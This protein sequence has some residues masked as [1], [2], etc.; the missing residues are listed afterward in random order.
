MLAFDHLQLV[1]L[2]L[3][4]PLLRVVRQRDALETGMRDDDGIPIPGGDAAEQLLPVLRLEIL[5]ARDEDV[6]A[7]IQRQQF[8]RELAEHVVGHG[9]HRLAGEPKPLQLHRGGDHR[10]GLARADDVGE[11]RVRRLQ[12]APDARPSGVDVQS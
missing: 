10:E 1:K 7:G 9:E 11:Q 4:E 6:R 3:E 2:F 5:L 12:N 8:G